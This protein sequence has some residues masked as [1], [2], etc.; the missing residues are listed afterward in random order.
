MAPS[1]HR[2][3]AA[4]RST[5]GVCLLTAICLQ[6]AC[7]GLTGSAGAGEFSFR[8]TLDESVR[9]RPF[10]GRVYVFLS[11]GSAEPRQGPAWFN[12]EPFLSLD[13]ENWAPGEDRELSSDNPRVLTYPRDFGPVSLS[14]YRA[15][16]VARFNP[17]ERVVGTGEGN[18]YSS[19]VTLNGASASA[20]LRINQVAPEQPFDET[21]WTKLFTVRS[22]RLSRFY[23]RDT[24]LRASVLLPA[25]YYDEPDRRYPS[26]FIIP[27]FGGTH[28][29]GLRDRPVEEHNREGV[30]FLRVFLDATCP[31][32]HHVFADSANNGP[33]GHALVEELIPAFEQE[34]RSVAEP[35]ARFLTGHSSGGWSSL[36][37]Q[38]TYPDYFGGTWS[39]SPDSVDFRDFQRVNVYRAGENLYVDP[40]GQ[41]RPIA[42]AQGRVVVWL[43]D[44]AW[45][46]HVL[47]HGGQL[48]SF[49]AVFSPQGEDGR[50][51]LIWDRE[52]GEIDPEVARTWEQYDIRLILERNWSEVGPRLAGKLHI[53]M[54]DQDTFYLEGATVLLK[55]TLEQLGS[56]AVVEIHRGRDHGTI[57]T[58]Q[59]RERMRREMTDAFLASCS[60]EQE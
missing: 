3:F 54:G 8:L 35:R 45:M 40:D 20:D 16:A 39:T 15:Q 51:R 28:R 38:I 41:R 29:D 44:F 53:H 48:H 13:V 2:L 23:G 5:A 56:D 42:R 36:W 30:E 18:G 4:R 37:L 22:E 31:L 46:E 60:R 43:D 1:M 19:I 25:S 17:W 11:K 49:E 14:G 55:A 58:E 6:T 7:S 12:T 47:G 50:P 57:L 21:K 26:V 10:S 52:T 32:G 34:Y 27:G 24:F 33:V 9:D 59:L